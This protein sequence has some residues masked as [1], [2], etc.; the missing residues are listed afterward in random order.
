MNLILLLVAG[1]LVAGLLP[2]RRWVEPALLGLAALVAL[3]YF[4]SSRGQ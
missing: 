2:R 4:T 1:A 3:L